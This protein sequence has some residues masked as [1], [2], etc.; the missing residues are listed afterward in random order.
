MICIN[1]R[2]KQKQREPQLCTE[3]AANG[4]QLTLTCRQSI[5]A[6]LSRT[7]ALFAQLSF[8]RALTDF[9]QCSLLACPG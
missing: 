6:A 9:S 8:R 2:D 3:T 7:S 1:L 5:Y 4:R